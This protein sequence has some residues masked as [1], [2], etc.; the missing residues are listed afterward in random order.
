MEKLSV[1]S[2]WQGLTWILHHTILPTGPYVPQ[3][4]EHRPRKQTT[5]HPTNN[6][7]EKVNYSQAFFWLFIDISS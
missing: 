2:R 1:I 7:Q 5:N 4:I 3:G 6:N